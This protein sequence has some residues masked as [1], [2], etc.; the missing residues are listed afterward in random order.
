[1]FDER[2]AHELDASDE[3]PTLREQ[4]HLPPDDSGSYPEA[5]Y[6]A[7]NSLGLQPKVTEARVLGELRD[8][9]TL[10]DTSRPNI[11]GRPMPRCYGTRR[12]G[13]SADTRTRSS[14]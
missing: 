13:W 14:R 12:P 11:R 3:L 1:M 7:G 5:A 10:K 9:A 2:H 8:W 6:F 4:F